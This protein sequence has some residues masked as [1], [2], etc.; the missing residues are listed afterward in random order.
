MGEGTGAKL[1]RMTLRDL[2]SLF[3][4]ERDNERE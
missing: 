3:G 4:H 2:I 1:G